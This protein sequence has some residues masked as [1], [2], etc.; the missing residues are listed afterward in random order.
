MLGGNSLLRGWWGTGTGCP[1]KLWM[2]HTWKCSRPGWMGLGATWSS[3][4]CP[5]PWQRVVT[6]LSLRFLPTQA[7]LWFYDSMINVCVYVERYSNVKFCKRIFA[8]TYD[9]IYV[10]ST[11]VLSEKFLWFFPYNSTSKNNNF[12]YFICGN[13][14][15]RKVSNV[16]HEVKQEAKD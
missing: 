7:I 13:L 16:I 5:C 2:S 15:Q 12:Y 1:E 11:N 9:I 10:A 14:R 6:R 3:G 4:R 8:F